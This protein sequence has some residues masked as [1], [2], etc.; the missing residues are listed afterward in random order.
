MTLEQSEKHLATSWSEIAGSLP[1][2]I[3][4]Q[5]LDFLRHYFRA[6]L[7]IAQGKKIKAGRIFSGLSERPGYREFE[8]K[9]HPILAAIDMLVKGSTRWPVKTPEFKIVE[10]RG[11]SPS[12]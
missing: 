2:D 12:E 11:S 4:P 5:A 3:D 10:W 8:D 1:E 6:Q 9:N 7:Q